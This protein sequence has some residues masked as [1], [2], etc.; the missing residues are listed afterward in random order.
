MKGWY[1]I[2]PYLEAVR[3]WITD[4]NADV[5][6]FGHAFGR[7]DSKVGGVEK[8]VGGV[9]QRVYLVHYGRSNQIVGISDGINS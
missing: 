7:V 1:T 8:I 9:K 4:G 2:F 6:Y 3:C 5:F